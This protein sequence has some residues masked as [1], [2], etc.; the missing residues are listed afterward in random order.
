[1]IQAD[2]FHDLKIQVKTY[3]LTNITLPELAEKCGVSLATFKRHFKKVYGTSAHKY[4]KAKRLEKS[5]ELILNSSRN[6][7]DIYKDVGFEE[8]AHFS[9]SFKAH[10]GVNPSRIRS[11]FD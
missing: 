9:K 10:F 5:K 6:I 4:M 2:P 1:M 11:L 7:S 3:E 8:F